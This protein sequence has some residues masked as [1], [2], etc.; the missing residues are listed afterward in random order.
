MMLPSRET[1]AT[2]PTRHRFPPVCDSDR[3]A[4]PRRVG[5]QIGQRRLATS[6]SPQNIDLDLA[7][8]MPDLQASTWR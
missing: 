3:T 5:S 2:N 6:Q 8:E 1:N 7:P 4:A